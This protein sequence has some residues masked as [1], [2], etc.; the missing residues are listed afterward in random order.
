MKSLLSVKEVG[1]LLGISRIAVFKKIKTGELP[2]VKVGRAYVVDSESLTF[3]KEKKATDIQKNIIEK[4]VDKAVFDY[5]ETLKL[6]K[7]V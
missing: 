1:G 4:A 5:G 2:A 3:V 6:L 7:D